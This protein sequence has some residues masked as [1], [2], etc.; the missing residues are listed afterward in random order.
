MVPLLPVPREGALPLSFAQERLW[1]LDQ[2]EPG[3]SLYNIALALHLSG[4][5]AVTTTSGR[6]AGPAR[7]TCWSAA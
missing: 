7:S 1:F 5:L 6:R 4:S 3:S 2:L